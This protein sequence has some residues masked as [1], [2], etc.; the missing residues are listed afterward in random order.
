M[1]YKPPKQQRSQESLERILDSAETLIRERG[2][3][4]MTIADVVRQSGSSVGSLY[5]RFRDKLA[6]LRAVQ[7]RYHARVE[8]AIAAEFSGDSPQDECLEDAARRIVTV[9]S[10]YLLHEPE[11]FRAFILQAVFDPG[12][13]AQGEA[14]NARRRERVAAVLLQHRDEI[15]HEDPELAARWFYSICMAFLRE[16]M[17]F[18]PSAELSGGFSDDTFQTELTRTVISYITSS[19][20]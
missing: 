2:F 7:M 4:Q 1:N 8:N 14:A 19:R 12:V 3:E 17:T 11:L 6:L 18:G 20:A 15:K 16:R 10:D 13:R 5:A 9:L